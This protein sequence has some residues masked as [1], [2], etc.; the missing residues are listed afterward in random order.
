MGA[1]S[2][3]AR[4]P[5]CDES[6]WSSTCFAPV[7]QSWRT[8]RPMRV[9]SGIG[10]LTPAIPGSSEE[11]SMRLR[12]MSGVSV[13]AFWLFGCLLPEVYS[14]LGSEDQ[15][16]AVTSGRGA[17]NSQAEETTAPSAAESQMSSPSAASSS[18][19]GGSMDGV[20]STP[21]GAVS[22]PA[23]TGA[24][25]MAGSAADPKCSGGSHRCRGKSLLRCNEATGEYQNGIDCT[26]AALCDALGG[27][28]KPAMC[29]P[30]SG[31]CQA[32]VL[33][34]C[35]VDGTAY[36]EESCGQRVCSPQHNACDLCGANDVTCDENVLVKCNVDGQGYTRATCPTSAPVCRE[37]RCRECVL[38]ADCPPSTDECFVAICTVAQTCARKNAPVNTR[39]QTIGR[40]NESGNCMLGI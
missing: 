33:R 2:L 36:V 12:A 1:G 15:G 13:A 21:A 10:C 25:G 37:G 8:G 11:D 23:I 34:K 26:S 9:A 35:N 29:A 4:S 7:P 18:G 27:T 28:C 17:A 32:N 30:G 40:C 20:M 38:D 3:D 39:C 5:L 22:A 6:T 31:T 14:R 19:A 24:S 16:G